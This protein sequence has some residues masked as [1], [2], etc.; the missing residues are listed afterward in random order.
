MTVM[1]Y[2]YLIIW[3]LFCFCLANIDAQNSSRSGADHALFFVVKDFDHW[4]DF[5]EQSVQQVRDIE[6]EL[7]VNYGFT[8]EFVLNPTKQKVLD[9]LNAYAQRS[10]GDKDQLLVYFSM[11]GH[12]K[13][14]RIGALIPKDGKTEDNAYQ[15]WI[16]HP[17]LADLVNSI[18][19][20]HITLA[21]DACYSGTFEGAKGPPSGHA[22]KVGDDCLAKEQNA[23]RYKS[24]LFLTSGGKERTPINSQFAERWLEALR[25]RNTDGVLNHSD[26]VGVLLD[27]SPTPRYG[28]FLE[29]ETGGNFVFVH[30]YIC[31]NEDPAALN[32]QRSDIKG[33]QEAQ[34]S[35][36]IAAYRR[37]LARFP[38]GEFRPLAKQRI[39]EFEKEQQEIADWQKARSTNT[40]AAYSKFMQRYPNSAYRELAE[41]YR[42]QLGG[43][44]ENIESAAKY[45]TDLSDFVFV[46]GGS[47][48]MGNKDGDDD[49]QIVH[50]VKVSD[51]YMHK[52]EVTVSE[53]LEFANSTN[54]HYPEWLEKGSEYH[55]QNG[56]N[57][58]YKE[59]GDAL[60]GENY[61]IVGVSWND[62]V[63]YCN[64]RSSKDG[65]QKVYA[66]SGSN[67]TVNWNANGYRLPTEAEWEYAARSRGGG[68][69]WGGTS[70]LQNLPLFVNCNLNNDGFQHTAPVGSLNPNGLGLY[71]MSGNVW[72]WC[73]DW[74]SPYPS[75]AQTD[76]HGPAS[77]DNRVRRGGSWNF[78]KNFSRCTKRASRSPA[79][80]LHSLGF[81]LAKSAN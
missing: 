26:L 1:K 62:A 10:F 20:D 68:D 30:K 56:N 44:V 50:R 65:L 25:L 78:S 80:R 61:P 77:G 24:R 12:Y 52:N 67:V 39:A 9:K 69:K 38:N 63:A 27:A 5:S 79:G 43:A 6:K 22:G 29:H 59:L 21:L 13:E 33:W 19:C 53:Y 23:L 41:L 8:S 3:F 70:N 71:D 58:H 35:N 15:T 76:P 18:D 72:E 17:L 7:K 66:I 60:N 73:W 32:D 74:H 40:V 28:D 57:G 11:H 64:W 46:K 55:Y 4:P 31:N 45:I 34:K 16:M 37:Y 2:D 75:S 48:D 81:R 51:F 42:S 14:G 36:T 49:E 54:S 47:F